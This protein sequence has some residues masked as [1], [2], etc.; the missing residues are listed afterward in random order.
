MKIIAVID[1]E[2]TSGGGFNQAINAIRQLKSVCDGVHEIEVGT[3]IKENIR[4]L[5]ELKLDCFYFNYTLKDRLIGRLSACGWWPA[6]QR[7]FKFLGTT[8]KLFLSKGAELI[9]FSTPSPIPLAL[10][11]TN[12][13]YTLWD[14]CHIERCEFQ[15]VRDYG[16]FWVRDRQY[17]RILP[18][19]LAIITDSVHLANIASV[20]YRVDISRF[21]PIPFA[22]SPFFEKDFDLKE[23]ELIISELN[24]KREYYYYPAQFWPHKN[25]IKVIEAIRLLKESGNDILVVFSGSD[26]GNIHYVKSKIKEQGLEN[27]TRFLAF[28]PE[29]KVRALYYHALAIVMPSYFGPTN[30]PPLEAWTTST[31]LIYSNMFKEQAGDAAILVDPISAREIADAMLKSKDKYIRSKLAELGSQR[32]LQIEEQR[33]AALGTL[34]STLHRYQEM[35]KCWLD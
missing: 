5:K 15:E 33:I 1:F 6:F 4:R 28:L 23:A 22:P 27:N 18:L 24:I 25:H 21:V 2:I 32:L 14:L 8:E 26:Q 13:I 30:L 12:Y 29:N 17:E 9:Y 31:P 35:K 19:A 11:I 34:K 20:R 7:K 3:T 10:Q 16:A